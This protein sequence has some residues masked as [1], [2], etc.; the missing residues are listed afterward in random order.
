MTEYDYLIFGTGISSTMLCWALASK[1]KKVAQ[2]D[3]N[4]TYGSDQRSLRYSEICEFY[5][6]EPQEDIL[7]LDKYFSIDLT[8]KLVLA[9]GEVKNLLY[10]LLIH[11]MVDFVTIPGSFIYKNN[12]VHNIPCNEKE[13]L[14]SGLVSFFQKHK[15]I[16]FFW[17]LKKYSRNRST[18]IIK[19]KTMKEFFN[20]YGLDKDSQE[21]I[22]HAIAMNLDDSYLERRPEETL[23]KLKVA[24]NSVLAFENNLKSPY[25]YPMYGISE[26]SQFFSRKAAVHNAHFRLNCPVLE[27]KKKEGMFYVKIKD[28]INN[29]EAILK[30]K[31]IISEPEYFLLSEEEKIKKEIESLIDKDKEIKEELNKGIKSLSI[32]EI[33]TTD[34]AILEDI[35]KN[36]LEKDIFKAVQREIRKINEVIYCTCIIKGKVEMIKDASSAQVIFLAS[37]LKRKN[38]IF[39]LILSDRECAAPEGYKVCIISTV[40]E[41]DNPE[42]EIFFVVNRLG[43][44]VNKFIRVKHIYDYNDSVENVYINKSVD[45]STHFE[46]LYED[47]LNLS[48]KISIEDAF[49]ELNSD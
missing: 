41:T 32:N 42:N 4:K 34:E 7:K 29:E 45:Q 37:E 9:D 5:G 3:K 47:V 22:G 8:P 48:K 36:E 14:T 25:I 2:I 39:L 17:D 10:S 49:K 1:G 16:S 11:E 27:I 35:E 33:N 12:K 24:I 19:N 21:F 13:A 20:S 23:D 30:S 46:S 40:K 43:N 15:V 31:Y 44:V 28:N 38:D 6:Q 18:F 26:I